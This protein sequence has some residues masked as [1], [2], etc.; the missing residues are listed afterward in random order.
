MITIH[1]HTFISQLRK[2]RYRGVAWFAQGHTAGQRQTSC[3][4]ESS[5]VNQCKQ[6]CLECINTCLKC[7]KYFKQSK[8][9]SAILCSS[10]VCLPALKKK[11]DKEKVRFQFNLFKQGH[12]P[13]QFKEPPLLLWS[14]FRCQ[15]LGLCVAELNLRDRVLGEVGKNS[16]IVLPGKCG[17]R[18]L[19][20]SKTVCPQ[21]WR[22]WWGVL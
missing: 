3:R 13:S 11:I 1:P 7:L 20:H 15:K 19:L 6:D 5:N 14:Y 2:L 10:F 16:F 12:V 22:F 8:T 18:G 4:G 9:A 17:H 21:P